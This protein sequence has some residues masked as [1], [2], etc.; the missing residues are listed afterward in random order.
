MIVGNDEKITWD[1]S[2]KAINQAPGKDTIDIFDLKLSPAKPKLVTTLQL[3]NSIVGPPVNLAVTPDNSLAIIAN[4]ITPTKDGDNWKPGP[5]NK[6][7]VIDLK[8]NPP[9][10]IA[11]IEGGKQASGL[12]INKKGDLCLIA[13]RGDNSISVLSIAGKEVKLIDTV[14]MGDSVSHVAITPDGKHALAVKS[15][16]NR[17][18]LLDIDGQ[19]VTYNKYDMVVGSFPYNV[20]IAPDGKIALVNNNG[21]NGAAD[22]NVDTDAVIDLEA[23]PPRVIDFVV[24]GDGPEGLAISPKGNLAISLLLR[25][26]NADHKAFFYHKNSAMAV[27]KIDGKKVRKVGEVEV[28]GLAE[29]IGF[30]P[31]GKYLYVGNFIDGDMSVFKVE[32]TKLTQ[33]G[34]RAKLSGH[35]ASLRVSPR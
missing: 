22:G 11:T 28:G 5:D 27:L 23:N 9:Q 34:P 19:K 1:E 12:S 16:A 2:G 10:R 13:N 14:A 17:V 25:G 33:A 8:A 30:S 35:P 6:I 21:N 26:S 29:G 18:A 15:L 32:G 7:Y 3:E 31:D 24:V 20:D 4:S